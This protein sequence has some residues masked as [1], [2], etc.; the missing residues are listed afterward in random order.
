MTRFCIICLVLF[1]LIGSLNLRAQTWQSINNSNFY[2]TKP[3]GQFVIN[4]FTNDIW[5]VNDN[6]VAVIENSGFIQP[7]GSVD[8]GE[9][10]TGDH[11]RFTFTSDSVFYM[12]SIF[13]LF[14]FTDYVSTPSLVESEILNITTNAD[15]I[16][17]IRSGSILKYIDG[18]AI[19][20]YFN[21]SDII[22]KNE[23]LYSDN[24][25]IGH[26]VNYSN[27]LLWDDPHYLLASIHDKK[28]QRYTDS[29]YVSTKKG[30]MYAFNYDILDTITPN[31][32]INM[33][34]PNVLE[35]EFDDKDS[36]WAVFGDVNDVPFAIS[37]LE[38][39]TWTSRFDNTN[40]PIDFSN[41]YGLEIDTL[42]N[43]WVAD[44]NYLHT[45]LTLN[46]PTWLGT[47]EMPQ[48]IQINIFPNPTS[49]HIT[50][51]EIPLSLIGSNATITD[52]N[53][54]QILDFEITQQ[55]EQIDCS[56]MK[57]GVYFLRIGEQNQKII[58]E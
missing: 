52:L 58:V 41:F 28:F 23:F 12:K 2:N 31:N 11:L 51:S 35:I 21:A 37:K 17:I 42:G 5:L 29:L 9:L 4:Q 53:G 34:S 26:N 3:W 14:N 46:S 15:T 30:V 24:G 16:F 1:F 39:N 10:W 22:C 48:S 38:G 57:K 44:L 33:P 43:L 47:K 55:Q 54:K 27:V 45:F 49:D 40:S 13:G 20:S 32:T 25:V 6:K 18:N 36:L 56:S 19:D 7:F 8:F 50:I